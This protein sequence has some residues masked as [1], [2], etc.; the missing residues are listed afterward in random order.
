MYVSDNENV[1]GRS[2]EQRE[3]R[4]ERVRVMRNHDQE[5]RGY[6]LSIAL[7]IIGIGVLV[8]CCAYLAAGLIIFRFT[9]FGAGGSMWPEEIR[10]SSGHAEIAMV[11]AA[12]A[13][14]VTVLSHRKAKRFS[15]IKKAEK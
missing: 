10:I 15:G 12:A 8:V 5:R 6:R 9:M 3:H 1:H 7:Q 11:I 4:K 13:L 14:L 2:P